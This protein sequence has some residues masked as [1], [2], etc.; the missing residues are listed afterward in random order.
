M[1]ISMAKRLKKIPVPPLT[2][3][4]FEH[5]RATVT[6]TPYDI[7]RAN[8]DSESDTLELVMRSGIAVRLPRK[9]I[10]ELRNAKPSSLANVEIQPGGDGI[11]V[12]DIDVDI[13]VP[14]LLADEFGTLFAKAMGRR[15]RGV[16]S[17]KKAAASRENGR[18]G[19]RP[20]KNH[21]R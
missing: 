5:G 14:G 20:R 17:A 13:F 10:S 1:P 18:K 4:M 15:T 3:E 9:Q 7:V 11:T 2:D 8:Y 16:T 19:G 21:A 12:R 6:E